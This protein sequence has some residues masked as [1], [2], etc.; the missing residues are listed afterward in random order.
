MEDAPSRNRLSLRRIARRVWNGRRR[1]S[2][3]P[4]KSEMSYV[5]MKANTCCL[6]WMRYSGFVVPK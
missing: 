4:R 5:V 6:V 3:G 1:T 2:T